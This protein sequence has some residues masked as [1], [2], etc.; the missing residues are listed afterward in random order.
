M[1]VPGAYPGHWSHELIA[2]MNRLAVLPG[3]ASKWLTTWEE[4]APRELVPLTGLPGAD[5]EVLYGAENDATWAWWKLDAIQADIEAT[6]PEKVLWLDDDIAFWRPAVTWLSELD[7][8]VLHI[9][10]KTEYGLT[11]EHLN[12]MFAFVGA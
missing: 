3:L 4:G 7:I 2:E 5:W 6:K 11:R 9:S 12:T 8:P 10:P 1:T